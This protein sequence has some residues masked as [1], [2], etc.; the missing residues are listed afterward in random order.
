MHTSKISLSVLE[1]V[2]DQIPGNGLIVEIGSDRGGGSSSFLFNLAR[3]TNNEFITVDIDPVYLGG[4]IKTVTMTG[5]R[6][7]KEEMP[8]TG[9]AISVLFLDNFDW[10]HGAAELRQGKAKAEVV[11]AVSE[12]SRKGYEL[13]NVN[14]TLTHSKQV[15]EAMPYLNRKSFVLLGE[16]WFNPIL[17]TF[18]GKGSAAV[19]QLMLNGFSVIS[20]S[21]KEKYVLMGREVSWVSGMP[22]FNLSALNKPVVGEK[23]KQYSGIFTEE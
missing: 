6:W 19:Y 2:I 22:R 7:L 14:S 10:I 17:D 4:A 15:A 3:K 20:A 12:Y 9:K 16:T 8:K 23:V 11:N 5:E 1:D 18:V 21:S 13:N